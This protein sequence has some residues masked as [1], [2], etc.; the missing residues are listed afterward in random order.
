MPSYEPILSRTRSSAW[1]GKPNTHNGE[2]PCRSSRQ[3]TTTP[4]SCRFALTARKRSIRFCASGMRRGGFRGISGIALPARIAARCSGLRITRLRDVRCPAIHSNH[5]T[6]TRT[7]VVLRLRGKHIGARRVE[8][9][10]APTEGRR[11]KR[12]TTKITKDTKKGSDDRSG[13]HHRSRSSWSSC[14][15]WCPSVG[16]R[17]RFGPRMVP[18]RV[19]ASRI[20][21]RPGCCGYVLRPKGPPIF[22][23]QSDTAQASLDRP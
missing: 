18:F 8:S 11:A 1:Q 2:R 10:A 15:S 4:I 6:P 22:R 9:G 16:A 14:P 19:I 5:R 21:Q 13:R 7:R 23:I 17:P 12:L 3:R 20:Q